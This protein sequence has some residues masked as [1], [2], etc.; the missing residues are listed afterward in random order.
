MVELLALLL[1]LKNHS[2]S[3]TKIIRVKVSLYCNNGI[4]KCH[5]RYYAAVL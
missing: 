4:C 1:R 3:V 2:L 5:T